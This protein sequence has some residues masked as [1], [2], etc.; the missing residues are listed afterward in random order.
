M[1][2]FDL[3]QANIYLLDGYSGP[4]GAPLVNNSAGY[5]IGIA[6]MTIDGVVGALS[7]GDRFTVVGD[8]GTVHTI[9][10]HTETSTN[11][12]S[13]TFTPALVG[14]VL[15]NAV[16]TIKPHKLYIRIGEGTLTYDEKRNIKYVMDR[17]KL[18]TTRLADEEPLDVKMDFTW[19]F[20]SSDTSA[21]S[22][23][24]IEEAIKGNGYAATLGWVSSE[25]TDPC[26]PF[27]IN[28][29]IE[30][31]PPCSSQKKELIILSNFRWE[32]MGHDAKQGQVSVSGKC[33]VIEATKSRVSSFTS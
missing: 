16:I 3:K 15:D 13:I 12:T 23:P 31:S 11:T 33:N 2:Q 5:A 24:S 29:Y 25:T 8:T 17:G 1:A 27:A 7:V 14:A 30:Y 20:L 26:A 18:D 28:V 4:G 6:T 21:D 19:I 22:A 9:T 32:S 10:A